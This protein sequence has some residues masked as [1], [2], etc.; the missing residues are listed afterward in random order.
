MFEPAAE[1]VASLLPRSVYRPGY[2]ASVSQKHNPAYL[3][4]LKILA[5]QSDCI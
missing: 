3:L 2:P 4:I 1:Q 5:Y